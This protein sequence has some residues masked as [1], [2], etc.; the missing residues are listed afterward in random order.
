MRRVVRQVLSFGFAGKLPTLGDFVYRGWRTSTRDG[1]DALLQQTLAALYSAS[2][3]ANQAIAQAPCMALSIRP[4]VIGAHGLVCVVLASHDRVGRVYP[5]CVG[6]EFDAAESS[7]LGWPSLA[8]AHALI[9]RV[10]H[11]IDTQANADE[12]LAQIS[13]VG[14]PRD[15][16]PW[17]GGLSGDD[18]VPSF[19]GGVG[20]LRIQ[21]PQA[22]LSSGLAAL[23]ARLQMGTDVLGLRLDE[24][25]DISDFFACR[26][27][28]AGTASAAGAAFAALFDGA[29][30][31]R[32]WT[33][34]DAYQEAPPK[35]APEAPKLNRSGPFGIG[36]A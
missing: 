27:L 14:D 3:H 28:D 22:A 23:C 2:P 6:V 4:G 18:T 16:S 30:V 34:F 36:E 33:S 31:A 12:L 11:A 17:L 32:G 8:Y 19:D 21:G 13:A 10:Q 26:R 7:A 29:W 35:A 24:S 9:E 25:G 1:L 15:H 5:L 20:W